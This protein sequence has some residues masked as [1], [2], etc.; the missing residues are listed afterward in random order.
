MWS[1]RTAD[2][3]PMHSHYGDGVAEPRRDDGRYGWCTL[4]WI[5][6]HAQD[7]FKPAESQIKIA[8]WRGTF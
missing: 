3:V 5:L 2:T 6:A 8:I 7:N 1:I 4:G